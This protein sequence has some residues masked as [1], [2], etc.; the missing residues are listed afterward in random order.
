MLV[1]KR[2]IS[3]DTGE[4]I[5]VSSKQGNPCIKCQSSQNSSIRFSLGF[6]QR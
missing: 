2:K 4:M 5:N 6:D 1:E 3:I